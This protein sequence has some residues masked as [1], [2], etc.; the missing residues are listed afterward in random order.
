MRPGE[1]YKLHIFGNSVQSYAFFFNAKTSE[2]NI[3]SSFATMDLNP[4]LRELIFAEADRINTPAF[5]ADDPVQ[6]P[7]RFT[8]LR[9]VE[10]AALIV[11]TIS[12]GKRTMICRNADRLL[13][14][15]DN[16][17]YQYMMDE[18][19]ETLPD[20]ENI[21]RTFFCR[22]LKHYLRGLRSIY[23]SH[24]SLHDFAVAHGAHQHEEPAWM[25][26]RLISQ[27]IY[28]ANRKEYDCRCIPRNLES[29]ALKRLNM[30]MRWLVRRDGIVDMGVWTEFDPAALFIPL[31]VHSAAT[32][33]ELRL[34]N[35]RSNDKKAVL[36][37]TSNLRIL[38]PSDPSR[39]D[40]ALF[41]IGMGL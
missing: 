14:R 26:A 5:I 23:N 27:A 30:A 29:S 4:D 19:Y 8:R 39:F 18:S 3:F 2:T 40:F 37:L 24:S 12:W 11:A 21:H 17:P 36:E 41:G 20:D 25:V 6:F 38:D 34:L 35:R 28:E 13:Q 1:Q 31:D 7:R 10:I 32:A 22:N 33:R 9:D 16:A 15:M